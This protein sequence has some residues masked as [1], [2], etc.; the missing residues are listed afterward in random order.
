MTDYILAEHICQDRLL[1]LNYI[2]QNKLHWQCASEIAHITI[3]V[4]KLRTRT[5]PQSHIYVCVWVF[6][7]M[8][9]RVCVR[10]PLNL[11]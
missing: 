5:C 8:Y 2:L 3:Y 4:K 6:V 10:A 9:V 11:Y 1:E 7:C